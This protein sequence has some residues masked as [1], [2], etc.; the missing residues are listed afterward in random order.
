MGFE[1]S[2]F[3]CGA[4][5]WE[6]QLPA[7]VKQAGRAGNPCCLFWPPASVAM[8]DENTSVNGIWTRLK[9]QPFVESLL[10]AIQVQ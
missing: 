4:S 3:V 5:R 7:E 1:E 2:S 9:R 6:E 10:L 8:H